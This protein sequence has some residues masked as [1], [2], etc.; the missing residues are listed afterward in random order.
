MVLYGVAEYRAPGALK[1]LETISGKGFFIGKIGVL[2]FKHATVSPYH[3]HKR[4]RSSKRLL[5]DL[6][7]R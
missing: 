6:P 4:S 1:S 7:S 3:V 5:L 2:D